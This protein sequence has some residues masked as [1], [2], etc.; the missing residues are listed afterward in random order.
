ME[1]K[2]NTK[3]NNSAKLLKLKH[4]K[5]REIRRQLKKNNQQ[6]HEVESNE[7]TEDPIN[8]NSQNTNN[9]VKISQSKNKYLINDESSYVNYKCNP[10]KNNNYLNLS[11]MDDSTCVEMPKN[12]NPSQLDFI[13]HKEAVS[14]FIRR[15]K[16]A[17]EK[18]NAESKEKNVMS[19]FNTRI[20]GL[21]VIVLMIYLI[22][23]YILI[24]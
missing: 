5:V 4:D 11:S 2:K 23:G 9:I 10:Q 20:I 12:Y 13:K 7:K 1:D 6:I 16:F 17:Y 3:Q 8:E 24:I 15:K 21:I 19:S 14:T 22:L 18:K